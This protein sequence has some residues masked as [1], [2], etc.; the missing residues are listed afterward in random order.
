MADANA[1]NNPAQQAAANQAQATAAAA[2]AALAGLTGPLPADHPDVMERVQQMQ[3]AF[4]AE[5]LR[6]RVQAA[7][8]QEFRRLNPNAPPV[9]N[10][11][12]NAAAAS[13][14]AAHAT[15]DGTSA[16]P[17]R[18]FL[19]APDKWAGT[20]SVTD[21]NNKDLAIT[22]R[23]WLSA[24]ESYCAYYNMSALDSLQYFVKDRALEWLWG[25]HHYAG[26]ANVLLDWQTLRFEFLRQYTPADRRTPASV[27][28]TKLQNHECTM[29]QYPTVSQ[30]DSAFRIL[31]REV[32]DMSHAD[33]IHWFIAGLSP[34]FKR[35]CATRP[36]GTDWQDLMTLI[37][38]ALGVE[39]RENAA[40]A[41]NPSSQFKRL[42][43]A[44]AAATSQQGSPTKK[45]RRNGGVTAAPQQAKRD[46]DYQPRP[47]PKEVQP[48]MRP[49][50]LASEWN[51]WTDPDGK[52]YTGSSWQALLDQRRCVQCHRPRGTEAGQC[53][54]H[55]YQRKPKGNGKG[56]Q[57]GGGKGG[58]AVA[59]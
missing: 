25:V 19:P 8:D 47:P 44:S 30:Y 16:A 1:P 33:Q 9:N 14:S 34:A 49:L 36:D 18:P 29:T 5:Q 11:P 43:F 50:W 54:G 59:A 51:R 55:G 53:K 58:K 35:Q 32:H 13:T 23:V 7:A 45:S 3:Q 10:A 26:T 28:R 4:N 24:Y 12:A 27:A 48:A 41:T 15:D 17:R 39:A 38:F 21:H 46:A 31:L 2:A 6:A 20:V 56:K 52:P 37:Q 42:N 57:G 22:G 40:S